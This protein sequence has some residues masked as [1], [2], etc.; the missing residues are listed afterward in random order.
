MDQDGF[1][2][3]HDIDWGIERKKPDRTRLI[4]LTV[5]LTVIIIAGGIA[6]SVFTY[7]SKKEPPAKAD[8]STD[9]EDYWDPDETEPD[10]LFVTG[11]EPDGVSFLD[12]CNDSE[13]TE[14]FDHL[15]ENP[16]VKLEYT[17]F[18]EAPY[19]MT[20]TDMALILETAKA[21]LTVKIGEETDFDPDTVADGTGQGFLFTM[22]DGSDKWIMFDMGTFRWKGGARHKIADYGEL[23]D[24]TS[25]LYEEGH[26]EYDYI[27]A[28]NDAFYTRYYDLYETG[29]KSEELPFGGVG[30]YMDRSGYSPFVTIRRILGEDGDPADYLTDTLKDTVVKE[31]VAGGNKVDR[32]SPVEYVKKKDAATGE[33]WSRPQLCIDLTD[34]DGG[35]VR[36]ILL[37]SRYTDNMVD[38]SVLVQF[39][40]AYNS[41]DDKEKETVM[42]AFNTA[43][44]EFYIKSARDYEK[45]DTKPG[46]PLFTFCNDEKLNEWYDRALSDPPELVYTADVWY[47]GYDEETV[48]RVMKALKTVRIG[49]V[50]AK[51]AG[52]SGRRIYDFV[53]P[54]TGEPVDFT[55]FKDTFFYDGISY[56]VLDWGDLDDIDMKK[57]GRKTGN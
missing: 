4:I 51:A 30:I 43:V 23:P 9:T 36:L 10:D 49:D 44:G 26:H 29:W 5:I 16:P 11:T 46:E 21:L 34:P 54:E 55:F 32:I 33:L 27:Y 47:N 8:N 50:S 6:A 13:L 39:S 48:V 37:L 22:E 53:D 12:F 24:M 14:W 1:K 40:A 57:L 52:A 35:K 31:L 28:D 19:E 17:V 2:P 41:E 25:R 42:Q 15:E 7:F 56:D 3:N 18:G 20:F 38:Q 45:G